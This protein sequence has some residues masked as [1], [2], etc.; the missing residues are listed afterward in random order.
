MYVYE[1]P[2]NS[3]FE[4]S[5]ILMKYSGTFMRYFGILGEWHTIE[6]HVFWI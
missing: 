1:I 3:G 5:D 4:T 6:I 2:G